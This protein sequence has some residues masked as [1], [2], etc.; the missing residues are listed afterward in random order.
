MINELNFYDFFLMKN[1]EK[2][3]FFQKKLIESAS[4]YKKSLLDF[5]FKLNSKHNWIKEKLE[6]NVLHGFRGLL[7]EKN[8]LQILDEILD[9]NNSSAKL[10]WSKSPRKSGIENIQV[11][12]WKEKLNIDL[13]VGK[14]NGITANGKNSYRFSHDG[15]FLTGVVKNKK[16]N[17]KS[18]DGKF[19]DNWYAMLKVTT[20]DGGS[21]AS[22]E[23]EIITTITACKKFL[24]KN[25]SDEKSFAFVLDGPYWQRKDNQDKSK[26]RF[27][28]LYEESEDKLI[29]C[30]SDTI[31][32]ELNLRFK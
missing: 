19:L 22:V 26:T 4:E 7:I 6:K 32:S 28:V 20:D 27:E 31:K 8:I 1:R 25:P 2:D 23:D 29:I 13:K 3:I 24:K 12:Y 16:N 5:N 17:T 15:E 11:E 30:T 18:L 21:T 10:L 14:N 9:P